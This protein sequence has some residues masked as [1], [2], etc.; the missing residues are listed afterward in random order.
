MADPLLLDGKAAA[1]AVRAELARRVAALGVHDVKPGLRIL[2]VGSDPASSIYVASKVKASAK[3][4]IDARVEQLP[5]S[6]GFIDIA[7]VVGSWNRD[8]SVHGFIIQLPL[9]RGIDKHAVLELI[10]PS[11]DVD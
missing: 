2:Q 9:P 5:D 10:G 6:A 4:G 7:R 8:S 11:K 3:I 1:K